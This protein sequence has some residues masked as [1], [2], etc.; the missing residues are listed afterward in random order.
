MGKDEEDNAEVFSPEEYK[1]RKFLS[2]KSA[3]SFFSVS[4]FCNVVDCVNI[5][6]Y[7]ND[8]ECGMTYFG[9]LRNVGLLMGI[10]YRFSLAREKRVRE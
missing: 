10:T 1:K 8:E 3:V 4:M 5:N 7:C 6:L 2:S 9:M